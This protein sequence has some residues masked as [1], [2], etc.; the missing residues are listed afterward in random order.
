MRC[1]PGPCLPAPWPVTIAVRALR[2][3]GAEG[4]ARNESAALAVCAAAAA[5]ARAADYVRKRLRV[6]RRAV[7]GGVLDGTRRDRRRRADRFGGAGPSTVSE[8]HIPVDGPAR[9]RYPRPRYPTRMNAL[10]VFVVL[11]RYADHSSET[12]SGA[13][14]LPSCVR[15][16]CRPAG[17]NGWLCLESME[18]LCEP[19]NEQHQYSSRAKFIL[20]HCRRHTDSLA[21][22]LAQMGERRATPSAPQVLCSDTL[23]I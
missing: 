2:P 7:A 17:V 5:L 20:C 21:Q 15:R 11:A 14:P 9:P 3:A 13:A 19:V 18:G 10:A 12:N 8:S 16:F 22:A 4:G 23:F 6:G 1:A